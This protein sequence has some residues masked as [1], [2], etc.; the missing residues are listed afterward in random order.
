[1]YLYVAG[2]RHGSHNVVKICFFLWNSK[3]G[4]VFVNHSNTQGVPGN[5]CQKD[6]PALS[7]ACP[8]YADTEGVGVTQYP[9]M[10]KPSGDLPWI[11]QADVG[12]VP[13][14]PEV[15]PDR[16]GGSPGRFKSGR[17]QHPV[18]W[19]LPFSAIKIGKLVTQYACPLTRHDNVPSVG[20]PNPAKTVVEKEGKR[21]EPGSRQEAIVVQVASRNGT[22]LA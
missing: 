22:T 6:R 5:A 11:Q 15:L 14:N 10:Y 18:L 20:K 9:L 8:G 2:N 3:S 13:V 1:M 4:G 12:K 7:R 17:F 19:G 21:C 16:C